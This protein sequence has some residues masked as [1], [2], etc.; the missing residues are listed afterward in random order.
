MRAGSRERHFFVTGEEA[1]ERLGQTS[2]PRLKYVRCEHYRSWRIPV[3]RSISE[4][5]D[6]GISASG[7]HA[8][9]AVYLVL[10]RLT[11]L[12]REWL[13]PEGERL[14]FAVNQAENRSSLL[15]SFGGKHGAS[16]LVA[17]RIAT[18]H[19][20]GRSGRLYDQVLESL[21]SGFVRQGAYWISPGAMALARQ[22]WRLVTMDVR[23]RVE[24][25]LILDAATVV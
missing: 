17:G 16:T 3:F 18:L 2:A 7:N 15:V 13:I 22:G 24:Y 14:T 21:T 4:I 5:P 9:D 20:R 8:R 19:G 23:E 6:L 10:S 25:D 1:A 12:R 11:P